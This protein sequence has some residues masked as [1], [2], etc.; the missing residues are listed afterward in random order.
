MVSRWEQD[1]CCQ[2]EH[3]CSGA[4]SDNRKPHLLVHRPYASGAH[5]G[6][7]ARWQAN[8]L[9]QCRWHRAGLGCYHRAHVRDLCRAFRR[10]QCHHLVARWEIHRL[11]RSRWHRAGLGCRN[12][13]SP[14]YLSRHAGGVNTVTWQRG[15]LLLPWYEAPIAS[16]GADATVQVWS[17]G[18]ADAVV[19]VWP[20]G[21]ARNTQYPQAMALQGEL[22]IYRGHSGP[23][24]SITW[25]PDG[26]LIASGSEDGTVQVW[27]A[28]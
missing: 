22:L 16:G 27:R 15:T 18:E 14:F 8:R 7:V 19:Q 6:L 5:P 9:G 20:V 26:Q 12:G 11:E 3:C 25:S 28:I 24:T 10:S 2:R 17:V 23:V 21:R 1:R 4:F 13:T